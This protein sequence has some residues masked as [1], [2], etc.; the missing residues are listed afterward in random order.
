MP[1][2]WDRTTRYPPL[3]ATLTPGEKQRA[4]ALFRRGWDTVAIAG[5][6]RSTQAAAAN[7]LAEIRD[8]KHPIR[9]EEIP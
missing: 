1:K 5:E 6:M 2:S 4:L 8:T 7:A 9:D 3:A